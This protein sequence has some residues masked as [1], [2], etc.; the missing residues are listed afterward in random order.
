MDRILNVPCADDV[1]MF[2]TKMLDCFIPKF[3]TFVTEMLKAVCGPA[4]VQSVQEQFHK[5]R[6]DPETWDLGQLISIFM[7]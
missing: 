5:I 7:H 6:A 2:V 4:Y 1:K 3:R